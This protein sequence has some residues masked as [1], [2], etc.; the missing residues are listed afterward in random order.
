MFLAVDGGAAA[1][2]GVADP[3]KAT[4]PDAIANLRKEGLRIVM[5]T[6][7]SATTAKSVARKLGIDDVVSDVLPDQKAKAV[8]DLQANGRFVAMTGGPPE[9]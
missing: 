6:G 7:D 4:T 3:I 5:L 8:K 9:G 1:V 2:L